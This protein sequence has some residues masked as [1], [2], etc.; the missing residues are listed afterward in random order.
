MAHDHLRTYRKIVLSLILR[1][2]GGRELV[3]LH[4]YL[5]SALRTT[6]SA[7]GVDR[8]Y[9]TGVS[10]LA[11]A[12]FSRT[13]SE[14]SPNVTQVLE[15]LMLLY[16]ADED[17]R[18]AVNA[19]VEFVSTWDKRIH[20]SDIRVAGKLWKGYRRAALAAQLRLDPDETLVEVIERLAKLSTDVQAAWE[21]WVL[22]GERLNERGGS[23]GD[24]RLESSP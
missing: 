14:V 16:A 18:R 4:P 7:S 19:I 11:A 8:S 22:E 9:L 1:Q 6:V 15:V 10:S 23:R 12:E 21:A 5:A 3:S 17:L 24:E 13:A 20:Q 2:A